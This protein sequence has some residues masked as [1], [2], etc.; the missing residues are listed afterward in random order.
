MTTHSNLPE[1]EV[2]TSEIIFYQPNETIRIEVR[3]EDD[4]VWLTQAQ[5]AQ[6]FNTT[7]Q[8]ITL[9]IKNLYKEKELEDNTTCKNFLQV[10][11][12]GKRHVNRIVKMYNLDVIIS[13]GYRVKSLS[14]T[15]FRQW[16]TK[17]LKEHLL[18]KSEI[19][20]RIYK[21]E[22]TVKKHTE[23]INF[24]VQ[25]ELPPTEGLFYSGQVFDAY[26]FVSN[27]ITQANNRIILIDNY[28]DASVLTWLDKRKTGV[29]AHIY[30]HHISAQTQLDIQRHNAQYP[31]IPIDI[32]PNIHDRFLIIDDSLYHIGASIKDLGKKLFAFTKMEMN[33]E[34]LMQF[35]GV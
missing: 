11:Q 20:N 31:P 2:S 12:E 22:E 34:D 15:K 3:M 27:L 24:F 4:T 5:M 30:T 33:A 1:T 10:Q 23:Q 14:G 21:I 16:A 9:H 25:R 28:I 26:I 7:A 6:L 13:V 18:G 35:I 8:N 32:L 29:S 17:L 19:L